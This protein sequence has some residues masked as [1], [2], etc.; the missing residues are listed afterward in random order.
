MKE[1]KVFNHLYIDVFFIIL[2]F[3]YPIVSKVFFQL[4]SNQFEVYFITLLSLW[5]LF[6]PMYSKLFLKQIFFFDVAAAGLFLYTAIHFYLLSEASMYYNKLWVYL[7]Y[8]LVFYMFR[9][10]LGSGT[11]TKFIIHI[12][13]FLIVFTCLM[14]S[15]I[16]ILQHFSILKVKNE[17]FSLLGSFSTPNFFGVYLGF[18]FCVLAWYLFVKKPAHR[19]LYILG[20]FFMIVFGV[21]IV[22]S[23]SRGA[24]LSIAASLIIIAITS[25][26]VIDY[27]KNLGIIKLFSGIILMVFLLAVT[28]KYLYNLNP[29]SA[30]GRSFVA[31]IAFQ[32]ITKRPLLGY[33]LFSFP[34]EYNKAKATYFKKEKRSW[35][36]MKNAT[37]EFNP[38]NDYLLIA[39]E[40]GVMVLILVLGLIILV[41]VNFKADPETR[42]GLGLFV[43]ICIFALFNSPLNSIQIMLVGLFSFALLVRY[44]DSQTVPLK[45]F[46]ILKSG[47]KT[48]VFFTGC[49]GIYC[50]IIKLDSDKRFKDYGRIN[51]FL[52]KKELIYLSK[53]TDYNFYSEYALGKKLYMNGYKE[54]GLSFIESSFNK[55]SS[56]KVGKQLALCYIKDGNYKKAED[57]FKF[58]ID[59]EPYRYEARMDLLN[60]LIKLNRN[61]E[62]FNLAQE[63]IDL[64]IKVPSEKVDDYKLR[65]SKYVENNSLKAVENKH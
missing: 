19:V 28:S 36:E 10:V 27:L 15:V 7:S 24:W 34:G 8:F 45:Q 22:I 2:I 12:V 48:V 65:A 38:F 33:G 49:L 62:A 41:I 53:L 32:E 37:Y 56:P 60:L 31:K 44:G 64:P 55:N 14:Q 23:N 52:D 42:I 47:L 4:P 61:K 59:V 43:G 57:I 5:M 46:I 54:E 29:E 63:I 20:V 25:K 21:L 35:E 3:L 13:L 16:G 39:F 6:K 51:D 26:N 11:R 30:D 58:N 1:K 17:Y 18:G 50:T 40:L 9:W